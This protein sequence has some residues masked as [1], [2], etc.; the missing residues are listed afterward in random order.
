MSF[1][2]DRRTYEGGYLATNRP[3]R[4][5]AAAIIF[6]ADGRYLMQLRD[7]KPGLRA[8]GHWGLFGGGVE[9]GETPRE[10]LVRELEEELEFT[11]ACATW[12]AETF[13]T[14]P[15]FN[16]EP[17]HKIFFSVRIAPQ[18]MG[19]MRQHEGAGMALMTVEEILREPKVVPW[20]I[21]PLMMHARLP[22]V[23][24]EAAETFRRE[25]DGGHD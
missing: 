24:P 17:T 15:Q 1:T 14:V 19:L 11:P 16:V 4:Q 21:D 22:Q 10:A 13:V 25:R 3:E 5:D 12:F 2:A 9:A 18:D 6:T 20:D 7:D 8:P 23:V